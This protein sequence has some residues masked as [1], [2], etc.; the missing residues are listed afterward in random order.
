MKLQ[1]RALTPGEARGE[2]LV[3]DIPFSFIGELDPDNGKLVIEGHPMNGQSVGGKV[4]V[5]PTSKG[6]TIAPFIAYRAKLNGNAP[7]AIV[8]EYADSMLCECALVLGIPLVDGFESTPVGLLK[9]GQYVEV[10]DGEVL[11]ED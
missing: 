10:K 1:G 2:A 4:L 7:A 11:L 9:T 5:C 3:L 8:C 6:G